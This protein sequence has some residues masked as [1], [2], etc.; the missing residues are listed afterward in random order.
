MQQNILQTVQR[1]KEK[2]RKRDISDVE[3]Y[4]VKTKL[5]EWPGVRLRW[6]GDKGHWRWG[7]Q[8]LWLQESEKDSPNGITQMLRVER[9]ST[10]RVKSLVNVGECWRGR[11]QNLKR[12]GGDRQRQG[13][14]NWQFI[15]ELILSSRNEG[16]GRV[17]EE[18]RA[19]IKSESL[20]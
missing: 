11:W 4:Q 19:P 15:W 8:E 13:L 2:F 12:G 20:S 14:R 17:Q 1:K 18:R 9:K 10:N 6:C 3:K 16:A 5:K 7:G